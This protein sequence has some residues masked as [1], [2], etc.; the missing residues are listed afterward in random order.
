M[1]PVTTD[2]AG[3]PWLSH[4]LLWSNQPLWRTLTTELTTE[5]CS[6]EKLWVLESMW[7]IVALKYNLV[8]VQINQFIVAALP[9]GICRMAHPMLNQIWSKGLD[10]EDGCVGCPW[11]VFMLWQQALPC[12]G[13][14]YWTW[15]IPVPWGCAWSARERNI[16]SRFQL[17]LLFILISKLHKVAML[18]KIYT[19]QNVI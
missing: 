6:S 18:C 7:M 3:I 17:F 14:Q 10:F 9:D 8:P 1:D 15:S 13:T 11:A 16:N 4:L 5:Q 2:K 19:K 12:F